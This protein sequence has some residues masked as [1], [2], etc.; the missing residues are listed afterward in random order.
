M[1]TQ[2][3]QTSRRGFTLIELIVVISIIALI[4]SIVLMNL[5]LAKNK[6]RN[7]YANRT[8][9]AYINGL[10]LYLQNNNTFPLPFQG[11]SAT[12]HTCLGEGPCAYNNGVPY[13]DTESSSLR[14]ALD[15]FISATPNPNMLPVP[16]TLYGVNGAARGRYI[17]EIFNNSNTGCSRIILLWYLYGDEPCPFGA[18]SGFDGL[19]TQCYLAIDAQ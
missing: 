13:Y 8:V 5:G 4:A 9:Y 10:N 18:T 12:N 14:A 7:S 16:S 3:P 15:P 17:C 11:D 19:N 1:L 2:S 6:T